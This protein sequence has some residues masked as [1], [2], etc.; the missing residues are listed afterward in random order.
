MYKLIGVVMNPIANVWYF[1]LSLGSGCWL[2]LFI[3][4]NIMEAVT[5][6]VG[7][8]QYYQFDWT[9]RTI[10]HYFP[11]CIICFV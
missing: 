8:V 2:M 9:T 1:I 7:C 4:W 5:S 11:F 10:L 6:G 3:D